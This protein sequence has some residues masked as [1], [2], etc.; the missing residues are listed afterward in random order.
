MPDTWA[1]RK[2]CENHG[3]T[4]G[5]Q[6]ESVLDKERVITNGLR[7]QIAPIEQ[8]MTMR[9]SIQTFILKASHNVNAMTFS[10]K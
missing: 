7:H 4:K 1:G 5:Q 6:K 9:W 8:A 10:L 3:Y 2:H